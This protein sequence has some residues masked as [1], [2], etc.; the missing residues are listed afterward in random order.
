MTESKGPQ[1]RFLSPRWQRRLDWAVAR[2][3]WLSSFLRV[4]DPK[5]PYLWRIVQ[6]HVIVDFR[7]RLI[8]ISGQAFVA[9]IPLLIV[10]AS[11]LSANGAAQLAERFSER[12][13]L[14][15]AT[16]KELMA[17]FDP[18]PETTSYIGLFGL[19]LMMVSVASLGRGIRRTFESRWRME[20]AIGSRSTM[21]SLLGVGL[22]VVMGA[23]I[24]FVARAYREVLG[25]LPGVVL[26]QFVIS[27]VLW[28]LCILL[29]TSFRA[30]WRLALP[31]AIYAAVAQIVCGWVVQIYMPRLIVIDVMRYG[32]IGF[33]FAL[34][35]WLLVVAV[36][37]ASI[38]VVSGETATEIRR[39]WPRGDGVP[40][41][42]WAGVIGRSVAE[43]E[44]G[45]Q[46]VEQDGGRAG[47]D[48]E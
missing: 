19:I 31:G 23:S 41:S 1:L 15:Q 48:Q 22:L 30:T 11:A 26:V 44:D 33:S 38:A 27:V 35:S 2:G 34:I 4:V 3:R 14:D 24:A 40:R 8:I 6:G 43:K 29:F 16:T 47:P 39:R 21:L 20:P 10:I 18:P 37:V 12:F 42:G 9:L 17:L 32:A 7:D 36:M 5:A 46:G 45:G 25:G 28:V 13:G